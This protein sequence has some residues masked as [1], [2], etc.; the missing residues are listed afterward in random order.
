MDAPPKFDH[1]FSGPVP[2]FPAN[3]MQMRSEVRRVAN[4]QS[5]NADYI[6]SLAEAIRLS[7]DNMTQ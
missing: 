5:N 6:T 3:F 7:D 2:T 1:L 4:R